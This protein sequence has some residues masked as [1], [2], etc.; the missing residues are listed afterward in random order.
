MNIVLI[1]TSGRIKSRKLETYINVPLPTSHENI[2]YT[3]KMGFSKMRS[4]TNKVILVG[5]SLECCINI[6]QIRCVSIIDHTT[7]W[8][9]FLIKK[10]LNFNSFSQKSEFTN[11]RKLLTRC[12]LVSTF[13]QHKEITFYAR[14]CCFSY[15]YE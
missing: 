15:R 5:V 4:L 9:I 6:K 12:E 14:I 1:Q 11:E 7:R 8:L 10:W 13:I 3:K 2:D